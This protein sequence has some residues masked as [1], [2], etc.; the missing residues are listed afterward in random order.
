MSFDEVRL[1]DDIDYGFTG[2]PRY[3]TKVLI[4]FSGYEQRVANWSKA[5]LR[6][7]LSKSVQ[8]QAAVDVILAFFN[9]RQGKA[10]GFRFKDWGDYKITNQTIGTG[11]GALLTFQIYKRYTSGGVNYD[12]T[13]KKI[14]SGTV[15][16]TVN[17]VAKIEGANPGGDFQVNYNTG[18]ITFNAG[19]A[20]PNTQPV[21]VTCEFDVPVRFD[22]DDL[23]ITADAY[24]NFSISSLPLIEVRI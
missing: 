14:V 6:Y 15:S 3:S 17:G 24:D 22:T 1:P 4:G 21:N 5:R 23:D 9:A 2:G 8:D 11:T 16:V 7:S 19:K 10:R 18:L 20:P 12:R 13:I